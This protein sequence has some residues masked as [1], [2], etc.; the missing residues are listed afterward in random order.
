MA[1][2]PEVEGPKLM[3]FI[4]DG[5]PYDLEFV[6]LLGSGAHGHVWKVLINGEVYALKMVWSFVG[7]D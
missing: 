3:P 1:G 5:S 6:E 4:P 7:L 2:L